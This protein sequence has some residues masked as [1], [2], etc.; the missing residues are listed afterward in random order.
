MQK[1]YQNGTVMI[2]ND[3]SEIKHKHDEELMRLLAPSYNF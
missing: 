3:K 1:V 2:F